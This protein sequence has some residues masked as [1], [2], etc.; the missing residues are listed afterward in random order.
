MDFTARLLR[1]RSPTEFV[2]VVLAYAVWICLSACSVAHFAPIVSVGDSLSQT[3]VPLSLQGYVCD[4]LWFTSVLSPLNLWWCWMKLNWGN[5]SIPWGTREAKSSEDC[6]FIVKEAFR[7]RTE[8][9]EQKAALYGWREW[10]QPWEINIWDTVWAG[11][12]KKDRAR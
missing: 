3:S 2:N 8:G 10:V 7:R 9:Q 6:N 11:V 5:K 1:T 12:G 4:P